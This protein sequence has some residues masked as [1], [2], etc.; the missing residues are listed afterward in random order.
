MKKFPYI[1]TN[2][3]IVIAVISIALLVAGTLKNPFFIILPF[4][5]LIS[6]STAYKIGSMIRDYAINAAYNWSI[7]WGLFV[8][9][10]CLS[11]FYLPNVFVYTMFMYILINMTLNPTLFSLKNRTNT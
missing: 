10:L 4:G 1:P 11:G 8:V 3:K 6:I 9:F 5:Y 2:N 7:K